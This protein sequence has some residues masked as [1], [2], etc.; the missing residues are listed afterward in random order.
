MS[1]YL[2]NGDSY[3]GWKSVGRWFALAGAVALAVGVAGF[4]LA[5]GYPVHPLAASDQFFAAALQW[6][7]FGLFVVMVL[8]AFGSILISSEE[9]GDVEVTGLGVRR[10]YKPGD[11]EFFP[12]EEIA[13]L[14]SRPGGGV[15][16]V[17]SANQRQMVISRSIDGYRD[18]IAELKAMGIESLP[19]SRKWQRRKRTLSEQITGFIT[20]FI[21]SLYFNKSFTL[22]EHHIQGVALLAAYLLIVELEERKTGRRRTWIVWL[23][24]A[25]LLAAVLW[26]W[27]SVH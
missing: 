13:G 15:T 22:R 27:S 24:G 4:F 6:V 19:A 21:G 18:C 14:I 9:R 23:G 12:R 7:G 11:D 16:L 2:F 1:V 25:V 10:I 26:R 5:H 17:D 20:I 8:A 3:A